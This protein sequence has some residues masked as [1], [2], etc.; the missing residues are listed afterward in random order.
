MDRTV[1]GDKRIQYRFI[2]CTSPDFRREFI[3]GAF[4][5]ITPRGEIV[6]DFHFESK[7]LPAEQVAELVD[8]GQGKAKFLDLQDPYTYTREVKFGIVMNASFAKDLVRL[9]N[10]KIKESEEIT[11]AR[12]ADDKQDAKQGDQA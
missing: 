4:S 7:D 11:A 5:N 9:L 2:S 10:E 1:K 6:C 8:D 12:A 3:N